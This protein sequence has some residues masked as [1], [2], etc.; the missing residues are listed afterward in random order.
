MFKNYLK[1]I[2]LMQLF[3]LL[4][5]LV[6]TS[7]AQDN[8]PAPS[9]HANTPLSEPAIFGEGLIS[10]GDYESHPAFS[11]DGVTLYF[12]KST[13]SFNF[14][15]IVVSDFSNGK[16]QAPEIAPFSGQYSDADPFIT[17]DGSRFY[18]ISNRPVPGKSETDLD[19]WM[20]EQTES[21]WGEPLHLDAPVNSHRNEWFP[22]VTDDGTIYFG[23]EREGGKGWV[24]IYCCRLVNGKY[25]EAEN[26]GEAINT[27]FGEF[28]PYV[29]ADESYLI[30]SAIGRPDSK[31]DFDLYISYRR[32]GVWTKAANLGDKV[33][34]RATEFSPKVSPDGKY[35]FFTSTRSFVDVP[36][37][38]R[39]DYKELSRR[40]RNPRNGLGDIYQID[41]SAL[42]LE[43]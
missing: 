40:L 42:N 15:T 31:G 23:S 37:T 41:M 10:T 11:P 35:L 30:F 12:L 4:T 28:E 3:L 39:L 8:M 25:A 9:Y 2:S 43:R 36:L 6:V 27:A 18:F 5:G 34:T 7:P 22:S 26:L 38:S 21:G 29:V 16:W 14:W 1:I 33:N 19:I 13:P 32:N 24:D 20:M 17:S